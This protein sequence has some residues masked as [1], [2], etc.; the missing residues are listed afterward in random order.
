MASGRRDCST[1]LPP[2]PTVLRSLP[3]TV[4]PPSSTR[5]PR[6][7]SPCIAP[8]P[9]PWCSVPAPSNVLGPRQ[10]HRGFPDKTMQQATVNLFADMGA[11]P[12]SLLGGLVGPA[13]Q[14]HHPT[15]LADQLPRFRRQSD[16]RVR[17]TI[18]GTAGDAGVASWRAWRCPR[19]GARPGTRRTARPTGRIHGSRTATRRRRSGPG[20]RRN[21]TWAPF[22][23]HLNVACPC[24]IFGPNMKPV[25]RRPWRRG[26]IE[27][28]LKFRSDVFAPS[29]DPLLQVEP[30]HGHARRQPLDA[31]GQLLASA[32]SA[33]R[34]QRAGSR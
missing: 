23:G 31:S 18:S 3:T 30:Q 20:C 9:A 6:T 14:R 22:G 28:G 7:T 1:S 2:P 29:A 11:Q 27:V 19:M 16:R 13:P 25:V 10:P 34:P 24:S 4:R 15:E 21:G 33:G 32:T 8:R 17:V 12:F 5:Q 26:S